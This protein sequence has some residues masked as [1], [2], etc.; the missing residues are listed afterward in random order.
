MKL[1]DLGTEHLGKRYFNGDWAFCRSSLSM[2]G[3]SRSYPSCA[4]EHLARH[5]VEG[6]EGV[7]MAIFGRSSSQNST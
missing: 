7:L 5:P 3:L 6:G 4:L 2:A 1:D